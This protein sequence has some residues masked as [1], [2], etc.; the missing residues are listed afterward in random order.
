MNHG[1][2]SHEISHSS[3]TP[4]C[5]PESTQTLLISLFPKVREKKEETGQKS[6]SPLLLIEQNFRHSL[7]TSSL[8]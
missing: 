3:V 8:C 1:A 6:C 4:T 2:T 5:K 7:P